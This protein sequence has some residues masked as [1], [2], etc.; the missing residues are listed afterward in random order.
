M[1]TQP[2]L[3]AAVRPVVVE[4]LETR[5]MLSASVSDG[6]V[7]NV[8]GTKGDDV[9]TVSLGEGGRIDVQAP[10]VRAPEVG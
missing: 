2:R 3:V 8:I 1:P 6:G 5:R 10:R 7:L 4:M 9:I